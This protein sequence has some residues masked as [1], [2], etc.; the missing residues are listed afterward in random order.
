MQ[1]KLTWTVSV[2]LGTKAAIAAIASIP[3]VRNL[4]S[5]TE[6]KEDEDA[7]THP[8]QPTKLASTPTHSLLTI[9]P[10]STARIELR[11]DGESQSV[12]AIKS[13]NSKSDTK[14]RTNTGKSGSKTDPPSATKTPIGT[15]A[16]SPHPPPS[17]P[18]LGPGA[19]AGIALGSV[20]CV[21]ILGAALGFFVLRARR[22]RRNAREAALFGRPGAG[23][24]PPGGPVDMEEAEAAILD[25]MA[26]AAGKTSRTTSASPASGSAAYLASSLSAGQ[27]SASL[28]GHSI[29]SS[30][31]TGGIVS[32]GAGMADGRIQPSVELEGSDV[33]SVAL[34]PGSRK[35]TPRVELPG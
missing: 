19:I 17:K 13:S 20:A 33:Q 10:I 22:S 9:T 11:A 7:L 2:I 29:T 3:T 12:E 8:S 6:I 30:Q 21:T 35:E 4:I 18:G 32:A 31:G 16:A 25:P 28:N 1:M 27:H 5:L 14:S 15:A 34:R 24:A 23:G 26:T